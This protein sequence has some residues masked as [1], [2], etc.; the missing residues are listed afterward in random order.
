MGMYKEDTK[1]GKYHCQEDCFL[2]IIIDITNSNL[3][4]KNRVTETKKP[5]LT[6]DV[7]CSSGLMMTLFIN[8]IW[9]LKGR[10]I[11]NLK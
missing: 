2:R 10:R 4:K 5:T 9:I 11:K 7:I 6:N 8:Y 3:G 1:G